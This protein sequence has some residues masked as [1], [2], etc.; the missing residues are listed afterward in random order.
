MKSFKEHIK[1]SEQDK[2][3]ST[4]SPNSHLALEH[5]TYK[6]IPET[7]NS[8]RLDAPNT[9]SMTKKHAH[10]YAK[11]KGGG[12]ELYS[13]NTDGSGHDGYS[14]TEIPK[15]HAEHLRSIGFNIPQNLVLESLS[16]DHLV[17]DLYEIF[18]LNEVKKE[19]QKPIWTKW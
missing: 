19:A 14:G 13:V 6:D 10:V 11:R 8:Y 1:I 4:T 16:V 3:E 17:T 5:I 2:L 15:K 18:T 12:S 7:N 9:N